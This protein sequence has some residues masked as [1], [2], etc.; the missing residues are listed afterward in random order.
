VLVNL[1]ATWCAPCVK[2]LPT[3]D[4]LA[5]QSGGKLRV[6]TISQDNAPRGSVSAFLEK[7]GTAELAPYHDPDM[8]M[9]GALNIQILPT[10]VLYD[11]QGREV[12]R[13]VGD[14]DWTSAEARKLLAEAR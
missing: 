4:R 6:V 8:A 7:L 12:W 9:S 14:L 2:E 1:W 13:Y 5:Q 10:S 3:L 11:S